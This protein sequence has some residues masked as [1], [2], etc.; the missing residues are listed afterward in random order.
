[1]EKTITA[2]FDS[3]DEIEA[4]TTAARAEGAQAEKIK[5]CRARELSSFSGK[6]TL[7][8]IGAGAAIGTVLGIGATMLENIG[9]IQAIGPVT[10]LVC[11]AVI[12]AVVGGF[13]DYELSLQEPRE[14]WLFSVSIDEKNSG[15]AA[16]MLRRCGGDQIGIR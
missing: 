10:G 14:R 8:G 3:T 7:L 12:G 4:A 9:I 16:K 5:V 13:T 11:G 6:N 15:S 1:M 2:L